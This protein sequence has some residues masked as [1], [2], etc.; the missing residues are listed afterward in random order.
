MEN[1]HVHSHHVPPTPP[2]GKS[3]PGTPL[4]T[5]RSLRS[6]LLRAKAV[7]LPQQRRARRWRAA[8]GAAVLLLVL[9]ALRWTSSDRA[10]RVEIVHID[11]ML[12]E[13]AKDPPRRRALDLPVYYL[14]REVDRER[15]ALIDARLAPLGAPSVQRIPGIDGSLH[16]AESWAHSGFRWE[17]PAELGCTL[18]HL[19]A[20]RQLLLDGHEAAIVLEDDAHLGAASRWPFTPAELVAQL[21][22][23]WTTLQLYHDADAR[24]APTT[25]AA[26]TLV[27]YAHRGARMR[28]AV[29]YVLSRR[30][31]DMLMRL[32]R[33]GRALHRASIG[34]RDGRADTLLFEFPGA[35]PFAVWPRYVIPYNDLSPARRSTVY[36][37]A[38]RTLAH[39]R[40]ARAV[41]E[42]ALA[43][44]PSWLVAEQR[45]RRDAAERKTREEAAG[46]GR[47]ADS[48]GGLVDDDDAS[49]DDTDDSA[50]SDPALVVLTDFIE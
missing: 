37:P 42:Q 31:A 13:L 23:E 9:P 48:M 45:A 1:I 35:I 32:T 20:A 15:R 49:D 29:G 38:S 44:W 27:P 34:T 4:R 18:S 3:S 6:C 36:R 28:G 19:A 11:D 30:G 12:S 40:S 16:I 47:A 50:D 33:G 25:G 10:V 43:A 39:V 22:P 14:N 21:P 7:M 26:A 17:S 2:R 8:L 5:P 24:H 46:T 41:L